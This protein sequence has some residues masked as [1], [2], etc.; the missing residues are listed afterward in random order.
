M[1]NGALGDVHTELHRELVD[2]LELP[3]IPR[4][5]Q[6]VEALERSVLG[7]LLATNRHLQP[8]MVGALGLIELQA[9]PR[10]RRVVKGLER[11]D[12]PD[13]AFPFYREHAVADPRHGKDWLDN[14]VAP[15]AAGDDGWGRRMV[16]GAR[17]RSIVNRRFLDAMARRFTPAS[18]G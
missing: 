4:D 11:V 5:E 12:A 18:V 9:G 17:W 16:Q 8:E 14:V 2:A 7:S 3:V 6:P 1:G 10:C 15:L 13:G